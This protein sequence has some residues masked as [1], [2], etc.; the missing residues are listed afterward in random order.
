MAKRKTYGQFCGLARAL[1]VV[2]DRWTLLVV[3]ELLVGA[4]TFR[5]IQDGLPGI[6]P[7]LLTSRLSTLVEHGLVTRN[8]APPRSRA[9]RYRLTD[10]GAALE[11]TVL[12]LIRWGGRQMA[13]GPGSDRVDPRWTRLALRALLDGSAPGVRD[14]ELR[15]ESDGE[16]VA[17]TVTDGHRTVTTAR[18]G[19]VQHLVRG[20]MPA[21]LALASGFP[22]DTGVLEIHGDREA[23]LAALSP[24][25]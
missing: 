23:A 12:E 14:A 25:S 9:V 8:A 13:V 17:I 10:D 4:R 24:A 7:S 11:P 22:V 21:I 2:G 19:A 1:D 5:E 6:G 20:P 15:V 18:A 16:P 3:R